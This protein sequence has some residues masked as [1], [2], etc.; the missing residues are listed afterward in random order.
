MIFYSEPSTFSLWTDMIRE[1]TLYIFVL[2][3]INMTL[4]KSLYLYKAK[5]SAI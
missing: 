2:N 3:S 1:F 5:K 4:K